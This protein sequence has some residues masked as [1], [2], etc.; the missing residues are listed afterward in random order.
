[1]G[2]YIQ[3]ATQILL[4]IVLACV[5]VS[6]LYYNIA[7]DIM[8]I[9]A[10]FIDSYAIGCVL[11][12][13]GDPF[14]KAVIRT[15]A[16]MG[17]IGIVIYFILLIG[18]GNKS[19]Y[20]ALLVLVFIVSIPCLA[21]KKQ[22][23]LD[24]VAVIKRQIT[25]HPLG[26]SIL[27]LGLIVYLVCG[28]APISFYDTLT[29]HLPITIYAA[30]N[31]EWYNN[32][33]ESI[34]Y[35]ESM[36][37]QYTYSVLF[38]SLGAYKALVL[39]NVIL[40][41]A[42]YVILCH[43]IHEMYQK[44]SI[45]ILA[46]ILLTTPIFF[47]F[48]TIFYLEILPLYFIFSAFVGMGKLEAEK[49]WSNI[50]ILSFICGCALFVKLTPVFTIAVMIIPLVF[51][52]I[53]YA[54]ELKELWAAVRKMIRCIFWGILPS[55]TSLLVI[56]HRTGNPVFPMYNGIF[57]SPYFITENFSD[58]FTNKLTFSFESLI[59]IVFHTSENIEMY[60]GGV[61]I[62]LLF[63]VVLPVGVIAQIVNKEENRLGYIIWVVV[64][65]AAYIA[66]TF[67]TYNLRYYFAVWILLACVITV[68]ISIV[69]SLI[70]L[71]P[72]NHIVLI[73][74]GGVLLFPNL[75][76]IWEHESVMPKS[77]KN[78]QIVDQAFCEAFDYIPS[79]KRVLAITNS[80][81]FKGQYQGYFASTTWHNGML[82][83]LDL[84][85]YDWEQYLSSF[86]Y[87]L[88]DKTAE[89]VFVLS[90][91]IAEKLP[92]YLGDVCFENY[93]S[94]LYKVIPQN[95][96]DV[97]LEKEFDIPLETDV[98]N[99]VIDT[100]QN[101]K[102]KYYIR[103]LVVN[104]NNYPIT[105]RFQINWMSEKGQLVDVYIS[106]YDAQPGENEY[107]SEGIPTNKEADYGIVY[108]VSADEQK[109]KISGYT[110]WGA[111]NVIEVMDDRFEKRSL[112]KSQ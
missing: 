76:Y 53:K 68:G 93:V 8:L 65:I 4:A 66:N 38:Y 26:I 36:V 57:K 15:A 27:F 44:S 103:H 87:I 74:T 72:I 86:D 98:M 45:G 60:P 69:V 52:C 63:I 81:Q 101:E 73:I 97:I 48:S 13:Q 78:E 43:F 96:K 41:F 10:L 28:S 89:E 32:V 109:A 70:P 105:M 107:F 12:V 39:F 112:L 55:V 83:K 20:A 9:I 102:A 95:R 14:E 23:T 79:G 46:V 71:K 91:E 47:E 24:A 16:G 49:I 40:L 33:T 22:D 17:L 61:G 67:T 92:N 110:V 62:F 18:I 35:G 108:M 21:A 7:Y 1:M 64:S 3:K 104:E 90:I 29:K 106:L 80:N 100:I 88:I 94:T 30:E 2:K 56:W 75:S 34:V 37:L 50:E 11:K 54:L 31:G 6:C 85:E 25:G 99:P 19:V 82:H 51:Y 59:D 42:V 111:D 77:H 58:V 5:L 84:G